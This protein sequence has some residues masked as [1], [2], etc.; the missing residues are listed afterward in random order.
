M[1]T[2]RA[3]PG[4][5]VDAAIRRAG[6]V[7][8]PAMAANFT[9]PDWRMTATEFRTFWGVTRLVAVGTSSPEGRPHAA[10]VEVTLRGDRFLIPTF[11]DAVRLKDLERNPWLSLT[12]WDDAYHAAIVYGRAIVPVGRSGMMSVTLE[13]T[14]IYAIR[15][16]SWHHASR[17]PL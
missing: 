5:L 6:E 14:R 2:A 17:R 15:P 13:P 4:D 3:D 12:T 16:P 11:A 9:H 7:A 8:G 10:P 1:T